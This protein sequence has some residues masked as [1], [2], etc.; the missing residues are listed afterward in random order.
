MKPAPT[1]EIQDVEPHELFFSTTDSKGVIQLSN[2]VFT[3]LSRYDVDE[4]RGAPHNIVRHPDMPASIFK[5]VWDTLEAGKPFAGYML[6][7]AGDGSEY[8]VFATITP[9]P[10]GGYLSV[11]A[12]PMREEV[13]TRIREVYARVLEH[14]KTLIDGGLNRRQAAESALSFLS[15]ELSRAGIDSYEDFE[16]ASLPEEVA[17]RE[18]QGVTFPERE[19]Q[20]QLHDMLAAVHKEHDT[21]EA[22]MRHQDELAQMSERLNAVVEHVRSDM[23]TMSN[24]SHEFTQLGEGNP[25]LHA[26]LEPLLVWNRMQG[27]TA[28]YLNALILKVTA[29]D[30][31]IAQTRFRIALSRLH[32]DMCGIFIAELIDTGYDAKIGVPGLAPGFVTREVFDVE[33]NETADE[34]A[35]RERL[36]SLEMLSS[37]L[38]AD[39]EA[40]Q[41][42]ARAY[43]ERANDIAH[44]M[45]RV[46]HAISIPRQLLELWQ[47]S[48][49]DVEMPEIIDSTNATVAQAIEHAKASHE[50]LGAFQQELATISDVENFNELSQIVLEIHAK[51]LIMQG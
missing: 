20:S 29:L 16:I 26:A 41:E 11:R 2:E 45:D 51:V 21:L 32:S 49:E 9:L 42:H 33:A 35:V 30:A 10:T 50:R 47:M 22:W 12:R 28:T 39:V 7:L 13:F 44:Y 15:E 43:R 18:T 48:A 6:N 4:L 5:L 31:Q 36:E 34:R 25:A 23:A 1:G 3:R 8:D 19:G 38:N 46:L 17:L 37:V 27:V 40:L 24:V 14:E